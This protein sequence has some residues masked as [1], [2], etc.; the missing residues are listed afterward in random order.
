[1]AQ[2]PDHFEENQVQFVAVGKTTIKESDAMKCDKSNTA[3]RAT[4]PQAK[5][6]VSCRVTSP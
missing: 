6:Q 5:M 4:W 1:M 3:H 2:V